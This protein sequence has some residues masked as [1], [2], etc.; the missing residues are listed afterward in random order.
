MKTATPSAPPSASQAIPSARRERPPHQE[1]AERARALWNKYGCPSGRDEAI[2]LEA[3][4]QLIGTD[5]EAGLARAR[6]AET[7]SAETAPA[8]AASSGGGRRTARNDEEE[9]AIAGQGSAARAGR[10]RSV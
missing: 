2:W 1:I 6:Q 5:A 8:K 10:R 9:L 4:R 7:P 3:E